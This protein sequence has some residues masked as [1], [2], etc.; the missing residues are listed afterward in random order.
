MLIEG[1]PPPQRSE[2]THWR[3]PA[4]KDVFEYC[5]ALCRERRERIPLGVLGGK[6]LSGVMTGMVE[7]HGDDTM[8]LH[9]TGQLIVKGGKET[10]TVDV[11]VL[12]S[13]LGTSTALLMDDTERIWMYHTPGGVDLPLPDL[14]YAAAV[15]LHAGQTTE[16]ET[17][18]S[19][20]ETYK[21]AKVILNNSE[22]GSDEDP[23]PC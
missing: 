15:I 22:D 8:D 16:K 21:S 1:G 5:V 12:G 7:C 9:G 3:P 19:F 4:Y 18:L 13:V 11:Q 10:T 20:L 17:K 2:T 14:P 6:P 23:D